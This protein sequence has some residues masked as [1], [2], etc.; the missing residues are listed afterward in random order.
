MML[1]LALR[2]IWRNRRRTLLTLSAMIASLSLLILS[3][4]VYSGMIRDM[5]ASATEQYRGH[6]VVSRDGYQDDHDL[7][8][9]FRPSAGLG[10]RITADPEVV[11]LSP[12]LRAY[13]LVAHGQNT[14]PA[15]LLGIEPRRERQVTRLQ[16]YLTAG[17][18]PVDGE[19]GALIGR[20]LA[21][22]LGVGPGDELIFVTQAADGSIGND[23]LPVSG[24]FATGDSRQ[25]NQLVLVP[26]TWLQNLMVLP[27]Q[28]HEMALS[29]KNPLLAGETA[30]RL[31]ALLPKDLDA[32][33][34][35]ELLPE[36]QEAIA[37]YDVSR[38]IMAGILYFATGLGILNTLFMSVME[39]TREF[40]I[41]L[42][43]G[44]RPW[45]IRILV[46]LET[47][48]M[49]CLSLVVGLALGVAMTFYMDRVGIDLSGTLTPVTYA[50]GTILP[51]LHAV[52]EPANLTVPAALLV[53]VA[54]LAAWLP[55]NRAAG[56]QPVE[57]L[58]EE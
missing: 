53:L 48:L 8:A 14:R 2:N 24:I 4:G 11:G 35:G 57:A 21:A 25:D 47:L 29:M 6:V 37:S 39:R 9:T 52:F 49:S 19:N 56:L 32:L 17:R 26:L 10:E 58:R 5:L 46:L 18:Y 22:R 31:D 28:V 34:W 16:Q 36:M 41:L 55:A 3:L 7:F 43:L 54:L 20:E 51:R 38:L 1:T 50:G 33:G 45:R 30:S 12:R 40:G 15:E 23:L 42:A 13:G 27:G 44:M